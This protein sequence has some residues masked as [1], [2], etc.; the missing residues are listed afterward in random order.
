M[1]LAEHKEDGQLRQRLDELMLQARHNERKMRRFKALELRLIGL[2]SLVE[3]VE[4]IVNPDRRAFEWDIVTL[5]LIDSE[6]E[7]R[8]ALEEEGIAPTRHPSL[9]FAHECDDLDTLYPAVSMFPMLGPWRARAHAPLFPGKNKPPASVALLPLVRH[10]KLIGSLNIGSHARE[11]FGAR[12]IRSD[13]LEHLAAVVAICLENAIN[14]ER[15]KRLGLTDTLTAVNNRRY[16]DQRLNEE[17]G[18]SQRSGEPLS[19]LLLDVDHFKRINDTHGHQV[20]DDVLREIAALCRFQLRRSDVL[21]RYGGE[22]FAALLVHTG[23]DKALEVA[24]RMRSAIESHRFNESTGPA[25]H[26]TASI[27][28]ATLGP[29]ADSTVTDNDSDGLVGLADRALYEAKASGR[30]RVVRSA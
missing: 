24:E 17:I 15:I 2:N 11:R 1:K 21:S 19:C 3:L 9:V 25:F 29:S 5:W 7:I 16:F 30:N 4:A 12:G 26:V 6:Y 20:G 10:G 13:F 14:L 8:R 18:H 22:E 28:V 27:G 23:M